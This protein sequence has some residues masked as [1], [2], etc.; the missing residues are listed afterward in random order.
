MALFRRRKQSAC[1]WISGKIISGSWNDLKADGIATRTIAAG[2]L[3]GTDAGRWSIV[4]S[5]AGLAGDTKADTG[6]AGRL[7]A[8]DDDTVDDAG[9]DDDNADGDEGGIPP[10]S[11]EVGASPCCRRSGRQSAHPRRLSQ[12]AGRGAAARERTGP[13]A[14][15]ILARSGGRGGLEVRRVAWYACRLSGGVHA[16]GARG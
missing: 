8:A 1:S 6:A 10:M 12:A 5:T 2:Y 3:D 7:G 13:T 15:T 14:Q 11:E 16:V 4:W 9:G